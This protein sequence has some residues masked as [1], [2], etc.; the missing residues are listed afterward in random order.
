MA[1]VRRAIIQDLPILIDM[2]R[3]LHDESPHYAGTGYAPEKLER[4]F[5]HLQGTLLAEPGAVFVAEDGEQVVGMAVCVAAERWFSN[6]RYATDLT[7]YV[8]PER[9]G[10]SAFPKL[11]RAIEAWGAEQGITELILGV[12]TEVHAEK[13]VRWYE[14]H[15]YHLSGYAMV[16][17]N[18]N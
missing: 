15:G 13:T 6:D 11:V 8:R 5:H 4:L 9:R 7:I 1:F 10:S 2:G 3:A 14:R 18:G 12:S 16:K 17:R